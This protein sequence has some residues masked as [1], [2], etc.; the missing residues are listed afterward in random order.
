MADLGYASDHILD[1]RL[2]G[3]EAR[4]VLATTLPDSKSDLCALSLDE[5][6]VHIDMA[7]VLFE[8]TARAFDDYD[9]RLDAD[10]DAL[11]HS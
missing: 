11:R 8:P 5:L 1:E 3:A 7:N 4:D 9:A 6:D 10:I 2:D